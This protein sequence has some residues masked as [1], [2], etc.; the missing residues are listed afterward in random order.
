MTHVFANAPTELRDLIAATSQSEFATLTKQ[1]VPIANPLFHYYDSGDPTIDIATGLAYPAKADRVRSNPKVGLLFG[2]AVHAHDPIAILEAGAPDSRNLAD[3]PVVAIA[4]IG[5]VRDADLQANTD[6]YVDRFLAEHPNI[7]P[8]DWDTLKTMTNYWVRIW[9]ECTPCRVYLWP[10]GKLNDEA[11]MIWEAPP[12]MDFPS[13]DP[14][15]AKKG[16]PRARW[17]AEPWVER[18][19]A[20][21]HQF[22]RPIL[23]SMT[24]DGFPL[25]MP[26]NSARMNQEGFE[27]DI[28]VHGP[29]RAEEG[30]ACLSFGALATFTGHLSPGVQGTNFVVDRLIGNLP[31]IFQN[32]GEQFDAMAK[33]QVAELERRGQP[34]PEIRKGYSPRGR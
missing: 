7:G 6:K 10:T 26:T 15:P 20:V 32:E 30:N 28:P 14:A 11:P 2:P 29:V 23:T 4:A 27:L 31:S 25:P 1:L 16:T 24:E 8:T 19:E 3:Q 34:M 21:L 13:S 5:A 9:V 33:R 18:A 12:G 22:P 17:P